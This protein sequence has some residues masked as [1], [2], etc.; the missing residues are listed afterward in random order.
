MRRSHYLL[1]ALTLAIILLQPSRASATTYLVNVTSVYLEAGSKADI[2]TPSTAIT[3]HP[4]TIKMVAEEYGYQSGTLWYVRGG[5]IM[6]PAWSTPKSYYEGF[7][8]NHLPVYRYYSDQTWNLTRNYYVYETSTSYWDVWIAGS[9][10]TTLYL[11]DNGQSSGSAKAGGYAS[12]DG[13]DLRGSIRNAQYKISMVGGWVNYVTTNSAIGG[14]Y[15]YDYTIANS[16]YNY[17][18]NVWSW[19]F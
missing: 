13:N 15:P 6:D 19:Y 2:G 16:H 1:L 17:D 12:G 9:Y 8:Y 4:L 14:Q 11:P 18:F 10:R 7:D 5:G 3:T